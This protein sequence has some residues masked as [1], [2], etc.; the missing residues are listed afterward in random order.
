[1][2]A[3]ERGGRLHC[4]RDLPAQRPML[5]S[6]A[7]SWKARGMQRVSYVGI[8]KEF[9]NK[10]QRISVVWTLENSELYCLFLL[11]S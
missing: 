8:E 10:W 4:T 2:L 6:F 1:M 5:T 3:A 7:K 11:V 9:R